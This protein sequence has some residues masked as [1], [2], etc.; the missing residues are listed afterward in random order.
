MLNEQLDLLESLVE[1][2]GK[3]MELMKKAKVAEDVIQVFSS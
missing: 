3:K 1:I 2:A